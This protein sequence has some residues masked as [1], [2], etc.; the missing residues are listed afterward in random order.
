MWKSIK[1][2]SDKMLEML[3]M[4]KEYYGEENDISKADF[5]EHE[6]FQNAAG[7]A[8]I[9]LA[10][11]EEKQVLAGQYI[12]IPARIKVGTKVCPVVLS[13]NT[14]TREAYRGQK[15][16]I[17][18]AEEVYQECAEN[19]Y[20]F[21]YGAPNPNSHPGFLRK[22]GFK[23]VMVIPLF[24]KIIHPSILVR[25]KF[26]NRFLEV[27]AK[28]PDRF[29]KPGRVEKN[30]HS[31]TGMTVQEIHS[32][33]VSLFDDFWKKIQD[34]YHAIGVRN[35]EYI[36][37]RY[38]DMPHR[39]YRIFMAVEKGIPKGY[40][41]GRITNVAGMKCGMVVDFLVEKD[42]DGTGLA[43]IHTMETFFYIQGVGL[44]GCLMQKHFEEAVCLKKA[45]FFICP[46]KLEPQ[47]FAIIYRELTP[48]AALETID[49]FS[50]WFFTMGDYD[51]I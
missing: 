2:T 36:K 23:D 9:K 32:E 50:Q 34:K 5:I 22:L 41:I 29:F 47:P 17:S 12:V 4:T 15:I 7:N 26:H 33:N 1:F 43:L 19:G 14:L 48:D 46:R 51:V 49:D 38:L 40:I 13:L 45:G 10:Y 42:H 20:R 8:F 18:L 3:S 6:Y 35:A 16:F 25:E 31:T 30:V 21:C 39:H 27:L 28:L 37:W 11:D 44:L 24:L